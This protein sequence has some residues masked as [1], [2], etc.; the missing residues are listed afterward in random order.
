VTQR[1]SRSK[2][3]SKDE[4][5]VLNPNTEH[6][7]IAGTKDNIENMHKIRPHKIA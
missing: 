7:M 3:L 1:H 4:T 5:M 2:T 6:G